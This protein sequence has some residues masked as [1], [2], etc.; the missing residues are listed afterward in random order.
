MTTEP[1]TQ[2]TEKPVGKTPA[3]PGSQWATGKRKNQ[4][5]FTAPKGFA[6]GAKIK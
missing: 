3:R 5:G 1:V 4:K 2:Q 6:R